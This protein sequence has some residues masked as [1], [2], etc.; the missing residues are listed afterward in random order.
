[1][2]KHVITAALLCF[3]V[4][5]TLAAQPSCPGPNPVVTGN[6]NS[7]QSYRISWQPVAG[8]VTFY[9]IQENRTGSPRDT[10]TTRIIDTDQTFVDIQHESI[11][12]IQ[13]TYTITAF[14]N[15]GMC[16]MQALVKTKGDPVLRRAVRRGIVPVV[17]STRG[18]NG[19]LF[20]T[21]LRLE[22]SNIRGKVIFHQAGR[23]ASDS[24]P[25]VA[26][27]LTHA[28]EVVWDDIVAALGQS[29][30][31]SLSIVPDEGQAQELPRATVRLYNVAENGIYGTTAEMYPAID[32]LDVN[33][34]FQRVEVPADGN[35]RVNVGVRAILDG[36]SRAIAVGA[37][38]LQKGIADRAFRAGEMVMGS[39]EAVYGLALAPGDVL[40]VSFT[41]AIIP[42]YTLTDNRTNDP[43]L[44]VQGVERETSVE[45]YV[46]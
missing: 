33:T 39:P 6:L 14:H 15:G 40:L 22:G 18:A 21:Y 19:A 8:T 12:D 44:Y 46:K 7:P 32:F 36:T 24:D 10:R 43:F 26:F 34:P 42:F 45:E 9:N 2:R 41:R 30:I 11:N 1:M 20:K 17:G 29:G 5:T 37:D 27:D 25:S 35:F 28:T 16:T 23:P 3:A 31:G 13:Y 4:V 38:G